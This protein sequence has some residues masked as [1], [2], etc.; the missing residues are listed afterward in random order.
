MP[1]CKKLNQAEICC[2]LLGKQRHV[3]CCL[4]S[5]V[6]LCIARRIKVLAVPKAD[7]PIPLSCGYLVVSSTAFRCTGAS[8]TFVSV[9]VFAEL[10]VAQFPCLGLVS[11][12]LCSDR[13]PL[14]TTQQ[15]PGDC[16]SAPLAQ[17]QTPLG[18]AGLLRRPS[19]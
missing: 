10:A 4:Y 14:A 12:L 6:L 15:D 2:S 7:I 9:M 19:T 13:R 1:Y 11:H 16:Y 8:I 3:T 17:D 18:H 5:V